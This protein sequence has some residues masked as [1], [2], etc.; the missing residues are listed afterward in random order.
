LKINIKKYNSEIK[1]LEIKIDN[2]YWVIHKL[3]NQ[4]NFES[5]ERIGEI[6]TNKIE[7]N[8]STK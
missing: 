5:D 7:T 4:F 8:E 3:Y 6:I 2:E 1:K